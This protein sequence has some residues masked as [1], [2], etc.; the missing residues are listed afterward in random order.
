MITPLQ[1]KR[2]FSGVWLGKGKF[3]L[4]SILHWLIPDQ[5]IEYKGQTQWLTDDLW[6]SN[7]VFKLS[8]SGESH[9]RTNIHI[10]EPKR[11]HSTCDDILGGADIILSEK[12]FR[13]TPYLFRSPFGRSYLLVKC[14]DS[15]E[16]DKNGIVH[17]TIKMYYH[18]FHLATMTMEIKIDRT[19][20]SKNS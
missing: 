2:F 10:I 9:R 7:E 17:D 18:G 4:H 15:A 11:L 6:I 16:I 20:E 8:H 14:I 13:F 5:T 3:R 19:I 1:T 12:G